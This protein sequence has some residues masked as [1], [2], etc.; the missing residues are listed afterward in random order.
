MTPGP[1]MEWPP[2]PATAGRKPRV[3]LAAR[4]LAREPFRQALGD[5]AEVTEVATLDEV[6]A[7][8]SAG[9]IPDLI[10]CTVY[11]DDS[12]MFD[13]LT[14]VRQKAAHIPVVCARA[15]P[16]DLTKISMEALRIASNAMGAAAF[17]DLP[18]LIAEHG[19]AEARERLRLLLLAQVAPN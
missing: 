13:L 6:V 12:R 16:K 18:A 2:G 7:K 4:P 11:F 9:E 15:L 17:V 1:H 3:L 8:V 14:W 5:D 10:C 19:P